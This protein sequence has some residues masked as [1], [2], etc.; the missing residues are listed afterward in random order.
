[1]QPD[2]KKIN[3]LVA[4]DNLINQ[5]LINKLLTNRGYQTLV[6]EDG[7]KAVEALHNKSF[8][9]VLMDIQMP[10]MDGYQATSYIRNVERLTGD[11]IPIIAVTAFAMDSDR[12]KCYELGMDDF[13]AKPFNK[14]D[15]YNIIE[16]H[17]SSGRV[18]SS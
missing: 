13:L 12:Q 4:E 14:M 17:L 3:I 5:K 1:M 6:V 11:H 2:I 10:I 15:F 16:K 9:L 18:I 8:D 7:L